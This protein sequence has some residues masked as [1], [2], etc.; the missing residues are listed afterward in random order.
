MEAEKMKLP[1]FTTHAFEFAI[2]FFW[3]VEVDEIFLLLL[4]SKV[5]GKRNDKYSNFENPLKH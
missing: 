3:Q 1:T 4:K 2:L 5:T